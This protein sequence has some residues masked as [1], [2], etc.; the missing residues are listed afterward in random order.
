MEGVDITQF[1][2]E[3]QRILRNVFARAQDEEERDKIKF[4]SVQFTP[5]LSSFRLA[6]SLSLSLSLSL[7]R[8]SVLYSLSHLVSHHHPV[9]THPCPG[10]GW[11]LIKGGHPS[12][13]PLGWVRMACRVAMAAPDSGQAHVTTRSPPSSTHTDL[14]NPSH[15]HYSLYTLQKYA[16]PVFFLN[17]ALYMLQ[18]PQGGYVICK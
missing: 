10:L 1:S 8:H 15:K 3:E 6:H 17:L 4:R 18:I 9:G 13:T 12:P 5:P 16:N 11:N 7:F 2:E 14:K